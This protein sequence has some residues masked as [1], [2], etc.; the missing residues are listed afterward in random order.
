ML[1]LFPNLVKIDNREITAE[2]REMLQLE[3][4]MND[5]NYMNQNNPNSLYFATNGPN[6]P[7]GFD[8]QYAMPFEYPGN[9]KAAY[10]SHNNNYMNKERQLKKVNY[11]QIGYM[12]PFPMNLVNPA[13]NLSQMG[14]TNTRKGSG[15]N[16]NAAAKPFP[17][18]GQNLLPQIKVYSNGNNSNVSTKPT[19]NNIVNKDGTVNGNTLFNINTYSGDTKKRG[20]SYN[21][22]N[23]GRKVK[24]GNNVQPSIKHQVVKNDYY[25]L[26][27]NEPLFNPQEMPSKINKNVSKEKLSPH[28]STTN[29]KTKK[30]K[31]MF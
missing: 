2:E 23:R 6:F 1:K 4:Q 17:F 10:G 12:M 31:K 22:N 29:V 19:P 27:N 7:G 14:L 26:V 25:N 18:F 15:M 8:D 20:N 5:D 21:A 16:A 11:I 13:D 3:M 24:S 30:I 28:N 9:K